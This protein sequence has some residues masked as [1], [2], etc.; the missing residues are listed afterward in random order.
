MLNNNEKK[1]LLKIARDMMVDYITNNKRPRLPELTDNLKMVYGAFVTL[2]KKGKLRGCIGTMI[3]RM[4]LASTIQQMVVAS[5]TKDPRFPSVKADEIE[6]LDIE[7]SVLS[8]PEGIEPNEVVLGK[9][10]LL[11]QQGEFQG[12]FLPQVP[13]EQGW[14]KDEYLEQLCTKAGLATNAWKTAKLFGFTAQVFSEKDI[15]S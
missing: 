1:V 6:D 8:I 4:P 5:S 11:I 3:G 10:G 13:I 12:V 2:H 7:I 15:D 9:H 14:N